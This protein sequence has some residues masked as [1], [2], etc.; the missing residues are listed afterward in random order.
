M[1]LEWEYLLVMGV[2]SILAVIGWHQGDISDI[3]TLFAIGG[4][5]LTLMVFIA[6]P[7]DVKGMNMGNFFMQTGILIFVL[8]FPA[9]LQATPRL[10][11]APSPFAVFV[12]TASE[13]VIRIAV[14]ILVVATFQMPRFA[15]IASA[16]TFAAIHLY[17]YPT[18]W[19]SAIVAG[20][21]FSIL[22]LYYESQTA[23]VVSHFTYDMFAFGYISTV[24]FIT[25]FFISLI[26]GLALTRKNVK[27]EI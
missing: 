25:I 8:G 5:I 15:V 3:H 1:K 18:E 21:L 27:V 9:I 2:V 14:F 13:E 6:F 12:G 7:F 11:A 20:A 23:C 22:L 17:W 16:I 10:L 26:F 19:F 4:V 24:F